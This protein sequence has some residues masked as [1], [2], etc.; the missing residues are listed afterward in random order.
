[1][2]PCRRAGTGMSRPP[3]SPGL[4]PRGC[5]T[6]SLVGA[7]GILGGYSAEDRGLDEDRDKDRDKDEARQGSGQ[8]SRNS[9]DML[10]PLGL[11]GRP[12]SVCG[13]R[14]VRRPRGDPCPDPRLDPCR[15]SILVPIFVP[16]LVDSFRQG[17]GSP[18]N[19]ADVSILQDAVPQ[20]FVASFVVSIVEKDNGSRQSSRQS[21]GQRA[22]LPIVNDEV[23][24]ASEGPVP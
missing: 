12:G 19:G 13:A 24:F 21:S 4:P 5:R 2:V 3:P 1:L 15:S 7:S 8:R 6:D 17:N 18:R 10:E 9:L 16:I 20:D 14:M 22:C 23:P 11:A